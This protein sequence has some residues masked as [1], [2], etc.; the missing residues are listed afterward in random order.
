MLF[1]NS[2]STLDRIQCPTVSMYSDSVSVSTHLRVS[3]NFALIV[4]LTDVVRLTFEAGTNPFTATFIPNPVTVRDSSPSDSSD[5]TFTVIRNGATPGVYSYSVKGEDESENERSC[6]GSIFVSTTPTPPSPV[7]DP[8]PIQ[9]QQQINNLRNDLTSI[10]NQVDNLQLTPGPEGPQ[11]PQ[12]EK[13]ETGQQGPMGPPG[14]QGQRGPPGQSSSTTTIT[15]LDEAFI[16]LEE[17]YWFLN[18]I[19]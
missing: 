19:G 17:V 16:D 6:I 1:P 7:P 9:L 13:G 15:D 4:E 12:G 10:Q 5:V 11:S 18:R 3:S 2:Y 8:T 14:P